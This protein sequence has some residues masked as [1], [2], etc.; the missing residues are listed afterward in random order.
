MGI[1][2]T[3]RNL[4]KRGQYAMT[5]DSLTSITDHPKIAVTSAEYRRI[6]DNLRYFQSKWPKVEYLN[7]DGIRKRRKANHLPIARTAAKKIASLV[8][9]EQAEIKLDDDIANKFVQKTL[10]NDRFNKNFERYLESCLALGGLAMRPY[11]DNERVRVSFVQAPVFLPLQS[12]TQDV[13]SA[14]IVTKT[15]KSEDK[16][17]VYYTLIEFHEWA[18]DGKYIVTNELYKSKDVDKVGD[19]VALAELYEDLE[20]TVELDGLSRPLF[21]YLKPPGMNNKDINSPLGL[22]I[23]DNAKSTIDFI[24][25]TYDEFKWEVKMGQRRVAVPENLTETRMVSTDGDVR[26]VQRFDSE[27]NVYLRLST[28]DMDGGQLTDLTTPIRAE[29]YIKTINEGL[30]LFEMLLGVSAGMFTFDGQSLKTATEVVS[31][32]SDTYQMRNSIVSLVEQSIKELIISICEIGKL[33]NLYHGEVPEMANITVNLDDGVFTDKNNEL[34]Y[35]TK[36][37]ASGLVSREYAIQ[38]ALG[39]SEEEA[40]K[41]IVAIQNEALAASSQARTQED[42]DIYGE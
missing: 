6:N 28:S 7:T 41:M 35:Y 27:Q 25:T 14:A 40:K 22:S 32:N 13:S 36:A 2:Q 24:N 16:R 4:F 19:R 33:Y 17:N 5:T 34:E 39:V 8:F 12:N 9:N 20:E 11:V 30:S 31:E 38:K 29:D 37:L 1:I 10:T 3:I 26:T 15:V 21:T 42:I 18:K 23:F